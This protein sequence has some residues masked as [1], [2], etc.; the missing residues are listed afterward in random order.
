MEH[1]SVFLVIIL[2][3]ILAIGLYFRGRMV[4]YRK[5]FS[6]AHYRQVGEWVERVLQLGPVE[7]PSLENGSAFLTDGNVGLVFT[8][9]IDD[10]HD[11]VHFS[12]SDRPGPTTHALGSRMIFF[13]IQLLS[14]NGA[15]ADCFYT[16]STVHYLVLEKEAGGDWLLSPI[17]EAIARMENYA[18]MP[19]DLR[20]P[21]P[22][23]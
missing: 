4:R 7:R 22:P 9:R 13:V 12:F 2:L 11:R 14:Q 3:M 1:G 16:K 10:E 6:D 8:C 18:P 15:E 20:E 5:I 23:E 17:D 21:D 19:L